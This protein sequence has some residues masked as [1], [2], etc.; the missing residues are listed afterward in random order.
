MDM[1]ASGTTQ[2]VGRRERNKQRVRE[3]I[4]YAALA[5]FTEKGYDQTS[6]D[7]IAEAADVARGTF[8]NHFQH[9][10]DIISAWGEERRKRLIVY[11]EEHKPVERESRLARLHECMCILAKINQE[12]Q[13]LTSA[14]LTAWV[15]AGRP[16]VEEP[17]VARIFA[18]IL[19]DG[20]RTGELRSTV[21]PDRAGA[22]L[23]DIY[24]GALYLWSQPS[25]DPPPSGSLEHE[26]TARLHLF[27]HGI[28][29]HPAHEATPGP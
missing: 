12:E 7:E 8:F 16:L 29:A 18:G 26:L 19:A 10:E 22:V 3:R 25:A 13:A 28:T 24:F 15:R 20:I 27:L 5:L 1:D 9:K 21:D 2:E 11:L 23:R 17:Y 14:M 6:V 4:Y